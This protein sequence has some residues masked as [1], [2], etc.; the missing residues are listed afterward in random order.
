MPKTLYKKKKTRGFPVAGATLQ[1]E[2]AKEEPSIV[3][4]CHPIE[5]HVNQ[6][7]SPG[8]A[9]SVTAHSQETDRDH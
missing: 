8:P 5:D 9:R 7:V 2:K 3:T 6:N 4:F 1:A